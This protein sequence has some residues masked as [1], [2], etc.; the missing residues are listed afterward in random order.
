MGCIMS[1]DKQINHLYFK[2]FPTKAVQVKKIAR[3]GDVIVALSQS[4]IL[5][6]TS[7]M[8]IKKACWAPGRNQ[9]FDDVAVCLRKLGVITAEQVRNHK[10]WCKR[11]DDRKFA[12][13]RLE[14][15]ERDFENAGIKLTKAQRAK[16]ERD[17]GV[18]D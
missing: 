18:T 7:H 2:P 14:R 10:A 8:L 11:V 1:I 6:T 3:T 9:F 17:A 13:S 12:H 15:I 16:L 5:Y 4:G